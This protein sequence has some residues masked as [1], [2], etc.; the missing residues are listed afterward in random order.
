MDTTYSEKS[1]IHIVSFLMRFIFVIIILLPIFIQDGFNIITKL[2]IPIILLVSYTILYLI[3]QHHEGLEYEMD[4]PLF[5]IYT[6][7]RYHN[8]FLI[9]SEGIH[10]CRDITGKKKDRNLSIAIEDIEN[11]KEYDSLPFLTLLRIEGEDS[12][13]N[14]H[15]RNPQEVKDIIVTS[16]L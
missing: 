12:E 5:S 16:Q 6:M 13:I 2:N 8:H 11:V 4:S 9:D 10:I 1:I 3:E 15:T 7:F 14:I